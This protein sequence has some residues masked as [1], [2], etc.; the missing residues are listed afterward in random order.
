MSGDQASGPGSLGIMRKRLQG[1]S[2]RKL[3]ALTGE[4]RGHN[5]CG[6][7]R[8][9]SSM[10]NY[11]CGC[12][13]KQVRKLRITT[14]LKALTIAFTLLMLIGCT[15]TAPCEKL[16]DHEF[17]EGAT[18]VD[19]HRELNQGADINARGG[20]GFADG[21]GTP[22]SYAAGHSSNSNI[23]AL[24]VSRGAQ[25]NSED[26][27]GMSPLHSAAWSNENPEVIRVL[28]ENGADIEAR[29]NDAGGSGWK[30]TALHY[31]A[32][33]E[34]LAAPAV[35]QVLLDAGADP[36]ATDSHGGTPLHRA[37]DVLGSNNPLVVQALLEAGANP[38]VED[39]LGKIPFETSARYASDI[40]TIYHLLEYGSYIPDEGSRRM[41][42][43]FDA[44]HNDNADVAFFFI[45]GLVE[46]GGDI[47]S[48]NRSGDTLL[49]EAAAWNEDPNIPQM[50][51]ELGADVNAKNEYG[52]TPL[53]K[54]A[55]LNNNPE[56]LQVLLDNGADINARNGTGDTP[57]HF[58]AGRT[59]TRNK[60]LQDIS[61]L[62]VDILLDAG[63]NKNTLNFDGLSACQLGEENEEL[64]GTVAYRRLCGQ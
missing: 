57:L 27:L 53:F 22:L 34:N 17:W 2:A 3:G 51:L 29:G 16:C 44:M 21:S 1:V 56:I 37:V 7:R 12:P 50:L 58:A 63:A 47:N 10:N 25:V 23:I 52:E 60:L 28:L 55:E 4:I 13:G 26:K 41:E 59:R 42:M 36:N 8:N 11:C 19:V 31:A 38:N 62:V 40:E 9:P 45:E 33:N 48:G 61:P 54:A 39:D 20:E 15:N 18:E 6:Q 30:W 14:F 49:H 43:F 35:V 46:L 24:L 5:I 32:M 64:A